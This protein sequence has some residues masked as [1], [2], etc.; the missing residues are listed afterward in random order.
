MGRRSSLTPDQWLEI[1]RR[2]VVDGESINSLA[3]EFNVNESSVRRKIKPNK[4][5]SPN[6]ENPLRV[7]AIKKVQADTEVK[8]IA[9]QIAELPFAKQQIVSDLTRKLSNISEHLGSAAEYSAAT[10]H[11]LAGI[12]HAQA[13]LV[14]DA[15]PQAEKSAAALSNIAGLTKMANA[16]SEIGINLLRANKEAIDELSRKPPPDDKKENMPPV[17]SRE[18]WLAAH[19]IGQ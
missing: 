2:H 1:E 10:A 17:L 15:N 8:R 4:A 18:E 7:I 9:E 3:A 13:E 16:A 6:G 14:D 12:A 11:R 19:G 5:E